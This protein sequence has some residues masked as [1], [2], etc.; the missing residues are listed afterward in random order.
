MATVPIFKGQ[1]LRGLSYHEMA[2]FKS[3]SFI[4]YYIPRSNSVITQGRV[5][6][7]VTWISLESRI[8]PPE[9]GLIVTAGT[10]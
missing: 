3:V 9:M 6:S 1:E 2:E 10:P 5:F 8:C 7:L 4:M